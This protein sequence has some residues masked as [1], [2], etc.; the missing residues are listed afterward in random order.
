M[1]AYNIIID[2][3]KKIVVSC[4]TKFKLLYSSYDNRMDGQIDDNKYWVFCRCI[5]YVDAKEINNN[6]RITND[7]I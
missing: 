4:L 2:E 3:D 6:T 1:T 7:F 5:K